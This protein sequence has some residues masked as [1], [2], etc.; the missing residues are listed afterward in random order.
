MFITILQLSFG[1]LVTMLKT[2][3]DLFE[4]IKEPGSSGNV[5]CL[6]NEILRHVCCRV[7]DNNLE[8]LEKKLNNYCSTLR[9]KWA[10]SSRN[11]ARFIEK[12]QEWLAKTFNF[13]DGFFDEPDENSFNE[14]K[15]F[16]ECSERHKMRRTEE[17][18]NSYSGEELLFAAK[19][20]LK[21]EGQKTKS[22]IAAKLLEYPDDSELILKMNEIGKS[23]QDIIAKEKAIA[24]VTALNLSKSQYFILRNL[25]IKEGLNIYP[26]YYQIQKA[27]L[28]CYPNKASIT[29]EETGA[30]VAL[31]ALL[32]HTVSRILLN[33]NVITS[34]RRKLILITKWGCDGSSGQSIYKQRFASQT[35]QGD[36]SA[37][38]M[39]TLVPIQLFD[40]QDSTII[41]ENKRPS[42][43]EFCRPINFMFKKETVDVINEEVQ[44]IE[45]EISLLTT[46]NLEN[47]Q[48]D[49]QLFMTMVDGKI[50]NVVT[51]TKSSMRCYICGATP[52]LMNNLEEVQ[53]RLQKEEYYKFGI[54]SLHAKI[55]FFE[56]LL[57]L[58]YNLDFK[59]W[60]ASTPEYKQL[61][62]TRKQ[63][64]QERFQTKLGLHVDRV[65]QGVGT[66]NDGNTARKF[67]SDPKIT[68]EITNIEED[69][70]RRFA[71]ILQAIASG[72]QINPEKFGAFG[73]ETAQLFV[74]HY[75][76]YYMPVT[77]HK[78]LIHG[79]NI[80]ENC[81]VPIGKM[82][83]EAQESLNKTFRKTREFRSRKMNR[84][85][86]NEDVLHN[87]LISSDPHI[88]E[89]RPRYGHK[90]G[91][92]S[93]FPETISLMVNGD[94]SEDVHEDPEDS[95]D[96]NSMDVE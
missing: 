4:L 78:V 75:G 46:T 18:R 49:H 87:L 22:K 33:T 41:W 21:L 20:K 70:I 43:S 26:S 6:K 28:D 85:S 95:D 5:D 25:S 63:L 17:I 80:I 66:Y 65:K 23:K 57:H 38:F 30:K 16:S 32:D 42:S 67:F 83:E 60:S 62:N 31:Q 72:Q 24:L 27:K 56:C 3:G 68:S 13:P 79:R 36:E 88:S 19:M 61:Q 59:K 37:L 81:L 39:S 91:K 64:I 15:P 48:I 86:N 89:I 12:N 74:R 58:S 96:D 77:V 76:W 53:Q 11:R 52:K 35:S 10:E 45:S 7:S 82:S 2:N 54:S 40:P 69:V 93:L 92:E 29:V 14:P 1:F 55:R 90:S 73:K 94:F 8:L 34:E 44:R 47:V 84:L 9:K 51:E 50:C 71:V